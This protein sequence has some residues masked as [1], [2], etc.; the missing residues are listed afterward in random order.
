[1][2]HAVADVGC[3]ESH[4]RHRQR[5]ALE[6]ARGPVERSAR[7]GC[8]GG[9]ASKW[10]GEAEG[11][12]GQHGFSG[13]LQLLQLGLLQSLGLG[14]AVLKPDLHLRLG[15]AERAGELGALG[16]GQVLL[17]A[18]LALQRQQ[19]GGGEGRPRLAVGLVLAQGAGR[20]AQPP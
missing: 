3:V 11:C 13:H 10:E 18:E 20:R 12:G 19:L 16:D 7:G 17:L 9:R 5:G 14:A 6:R 1:M 2:V 4:G 8:Y 15:E